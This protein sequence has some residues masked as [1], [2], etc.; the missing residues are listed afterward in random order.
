MG[1]PGFPTRLL[2]L[3]EP[4][5]ALRLSGDGSLLLAS[6]VAILGSR[7]APGSRVRLAADLAHAA[8]AAGLVVVAGASTALE[9][10]ALEAAGDR[11]V[12]VD[13]GAMPGAD[14]AGAGLPAAHPRAAL[15]AWEDPDSRRLPRA[16][17]RPAGPARRA[18]SRARGI[19]VAIARAVVIVAASRESEVMQAAG[20]AGLLGRPLFALEP[21]TDEPL[22][23]LDALVR[24][25]LALPL[26]R[27]EASALFERLAKTGGG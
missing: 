12:V 13:P 19:Q 26:A 24:S 2:D 16:A 21:A 5:R 3:D 14:P 17:T 6:A 4:P 7:T 15:V 22:A 18:R 10:A 23:G 1:D 8:R 11:T 27:D 9:R 20:W 25:G